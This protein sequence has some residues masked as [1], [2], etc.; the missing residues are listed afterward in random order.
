MG[1]KSFEEFMVGVVEEQVGLGWFRRDGGRDS[2]NRCLTER[3][4][5]GIF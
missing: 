4:S 3:R 1:A 5:S 2:G